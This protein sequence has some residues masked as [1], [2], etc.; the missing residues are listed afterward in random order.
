MNAMV[1]QCESVGTKEGKE[2]PGRR[3]GCEEPAKC[4]TS[5][6]NRSPICGG[7][8]ERPESLE[9]GDPKCTPER[10]DV[11]GDVDVDE[12]VSCQ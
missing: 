9:G 3:S 7:D 10:D 2:S 11:L 12:D 1:H 6:W 4:G 8:E 5:L